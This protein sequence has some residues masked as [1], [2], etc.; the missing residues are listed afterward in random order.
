[1]RLIIALLLCLV[2]S[3]CSGYEIKNLVKSDID[4]VADEFIA[5]TRSVVRELVIKLYKRNPAELGLRSVRRHKGE[6]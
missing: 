6:Q 4:L 2:L 3:A 1:M 5:E